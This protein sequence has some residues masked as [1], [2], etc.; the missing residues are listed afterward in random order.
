MN[1]STATESS[2]VRYQGR[3]ELFFTTVWGD[4]FLESHGIEHHRRVWN[5][6]KKLLSHSADRIAGDDPLLTDKLIIACYLHDLGMAVNRGTDHGLQSKE[7]CTRFLEENDLPL[8]EFGDLLSA[9]GYH[10]R[11]DQENRENQINLSSL[12]GTADDLDAFG[13]TGIYRYIEIYAARGTGNSEMGK[14]V[15]GNAAGR[16][17]NFI[18][19]FGFSKSLIMEHKI[20]Y[21]TVELFFN[22]LRYETERSGSGSSADSGY[23]KVIEHV[24]N[25]MI[26]RIPCRTYISEVTGTTDDNVVRWFFRNLSKESDIG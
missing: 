14:T 18:S 25:A 19:L 5:Y 26:S 21:E 8:S 15:I 13:F 2:E 24:R 9:V 7:E 12:L 11:K 4:T 23:N 17:K 16:F 6:V 20:R 3:L 10:D 22:E 1:F